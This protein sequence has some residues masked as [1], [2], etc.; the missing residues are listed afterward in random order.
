MILKTTF[1]LTSIG[2]ILWKRKIMIMNQ[3]IRLYLKSLNF[4]FLL[5]KPFSQLSHILKKDRNK[6]S[7]FSVKGILHSK[8]ICTKATV[9][10][11]LM[12]NVKA[13]YARYAAKTALKEANTDQTLK[14]KLEK[15][16]NDQ[17]NKNVKLRDIKEQKG[18]LQ[19]NEENL[20]LTQDKVN[21]KMK[22][23]QELMEKAQ[24]MYKVI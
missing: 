6:L 22:E 1:L 12:Y 20:K 24:K 16:V 7:L 19:Q 8:E 18:I 11:R 4:D 14:R 2:K 23:A 10:D 3:N 5:L 13:A 17:C 21:L 15:E 9:D